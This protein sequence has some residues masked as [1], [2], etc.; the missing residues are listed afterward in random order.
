MVREKDILKQ[1]F[2]VAVLVLILVSIF[3]ELVRV[4]SNLKS[5]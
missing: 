4:E 1:V 5:I 3:I 2:L